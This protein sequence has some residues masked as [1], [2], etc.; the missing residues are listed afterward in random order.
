MIIQTN[1]IPE[2]REFIDLRGFILPLEDRFNILYFMLET[3]I[4]PVI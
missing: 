3:S 2:C 1:T 4:E